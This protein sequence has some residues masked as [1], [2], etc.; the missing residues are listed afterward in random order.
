MSF[1]A[2]MHRCR[3]ATAILA[4]FF[5]S[6]SSAIMGRSVCEAAFAAPAGFVAQRTTT[7]ISNGLGTTG[8]RRRGFVSLP[9]S[10]S[11][12]FDSPDDDGGKRISVTGTIYDGPEGEPVVQ[13][14]TKQGCT[15]C[16]K[17]TEILRSVKESNP[18]TLE[19][20]D[21][22]DEDKSDWYDK[23]KYDIPVLHIE[24]KYWSKHRLASEVAVEGLEAAKAGTFE[25]QAGEPNAG[26]MERRQAER[27]Q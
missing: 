5:P 14:F 24:G 23:Y 4:T 9:P 13:L 12:G 27:Q 19:A 1:A 25:P 20:V 2:I 15:L 17:V 21:I 6:C 22:T 8:A 10:R 16:D 26:E 11:A 18:H 3:A 7:R